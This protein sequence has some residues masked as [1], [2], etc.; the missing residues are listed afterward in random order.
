MSKK[1]HAL[2]LGIESDASSGNKINRLFTLSHPNVN[3]A[4]TDLIISREWPEW[5]VGRMR[6]VQ[7]L[8]HSVF[9]VNFEYINFFN[10]MSIYVFLFLFQSHHKSIQISKYHYI[11]FIYRKIYKC[12]NRKWYLHF[13]IT[14]PIRASKIN[15]EY[16]YWK[17]LKRLNFSSSDFSHRWAFN[18]FIYCSFSTQKSHAQ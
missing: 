11:S 15:T 16:W 3:V 14:R 12:I 18:A 17:I 6:R 13:V 8:E 9:H 10:E 5:P 2:S 4:W 7:F 1:K